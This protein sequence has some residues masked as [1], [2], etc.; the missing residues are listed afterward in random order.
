MPTKTL[1]ISP[2]DWVS[3]ETTLQISYPS[4]A[5]PA[6][7]IMT[8][9]PGDLKWV[10]L[11]L[12]LPP[13]TEIKAVRVCYQVS[14]SRSFISQVRLTE[15]KTPD[16]ALVRHDDP[17]DLTSVDPT[18]HV[19]EV[20]NLH[21]E[22]AITL[23]LRLNFG[24][25]ADKI[26]IGAV[27]VDLRNYGASKIW[28]P[29]RRPVAVIPCYNG[30]AGNTYGLSP[31]WFT[32]GVPRLREVLTELWDRGFQRFMLNL[33]AGRER[34]EDGT[35]PGYPSAQWQ[36]L[37]TAGIH[38]PSG[39]VQRDL[40]ECITPWLADRPEAQA[41]IYF[42]FQIKRSDDR[43]MEGAVV[44][45]MNRADHRTIVEANMD[46]F[47][48]LTP[49]ACMPQIGFRLES[50]STPELRDGLVALSDWFRAEPIS[51]GGEAIPVDGN[52]GF[53]PVLV[54]RCPWV[55]LYRFHRQRDPGRL[56]EF[57]PLNTEVGLWLHSIERINSLSYWNDDSAALEKFRINDPAE[58]IEEFRN[59][60][61]IFYIHYSVPIAGTPVSDWE[62]V[63]LAT[64]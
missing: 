40:A 6:T 13:C 46:G 1:W 4:V 10:F 57:E 58:V 16:Q 44:P 32:H 29:D 8:T 33:P 51:I 41:L 26:I 53:T 12:R 14:N 37:D 63:V 56:W 5:H 47:I 54:D 35:A 61:N 9:K 3:G 36:V 2:T 34:P 18:C 39:S 11:A 31:F 60:G 52:G 21:P 25:R 42:G 48:N 50:A 43:D 17:T 38:S 64:A 19:S 7:E 24:H 27:G 55:A 15:M 62:S 45:D 23:A 30:N 49:N 20:P 59:R 28:R 22:G